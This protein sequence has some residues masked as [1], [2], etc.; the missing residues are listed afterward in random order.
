L[1]CQF[2]S[3]CT[4]S[5]AS[6]VLAGPSSLWLFLLCCLGISKIAFKDSNSRLHM[7][8]FRE[9]KKFWTKSALALWKQC[10]ESGSTDWTDALHHC[11]IASLHHC[12]IAANGKYVEWSKQWPTKLFLTAP[13][14]GDA[15]PIAKYPISVSSPK[16]Q[17]V[18]DEWAWLILWENHKYY[19]VAF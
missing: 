18:E 8:F 14:S 9:S 11:I 17:R 12:I 10:S 13:R 7:I 4:I 15:H 3:N 6:I 19:I 1:Q 16:C 2:I 5:T